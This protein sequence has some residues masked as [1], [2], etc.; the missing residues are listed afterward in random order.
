[1]ENNQPEVKQLA[2]RHVAYLSYTGNYIGNTKVFCDLFTKL[3]NWAG[4][5]GL[6]GPERVFLSSYKDYPRVTP[7]EELVLEVCL[8]RLKSKVKS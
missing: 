2:D 8:S 7:P 6:F 1:M 4:P 3:G 5:K